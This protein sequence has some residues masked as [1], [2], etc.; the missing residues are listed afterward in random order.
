L[1][2]QRRSPL[3]PELDLL[4]AE[5]NWCQTPFFVPGKIGV[6]HRF[7]DKG[8]TPFLFDDELDAAE[9]RE[10][11]AVAVDDRGGAVRAARHRPEPRRPLRRDRKSTRLNSSHVKT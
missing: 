5:D 3:L 1:R 11:Y 9:L 6:R 10:T 2:A 4:I 8:Q 7:S